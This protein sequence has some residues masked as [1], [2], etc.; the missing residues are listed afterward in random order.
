VSFPVSKAVADVRRIAYGRLRPVRNILGTT[1]DATTTTVSLTLGTSEGVTV[2]V[3]SY[4][5]IDRELMWAYTNTATTTTQTL[6]VARG[7]YGTTAAAH[8]SGARVGV[9]SRF[10]DAF[11]ADAIRD[12]ILGWQPDLFQPVAVDYTVD[13]WPGTV[14]V[15][16]DAVGSFGP[17]AARYL[18]STASSTQYPE[19]EWR[20]MQGMDLASFPS[21]EAIEFLEPT[22]APA[23]WSAQTTSAGSVRVVWA[24]PFD[25]ETF[26]D[27]TDLVESCGLAPSM[28]DVAVLGA[29]IRLLATSEVQRSDMGTAGQPRD[30]AEVSGGAQLQA[31]AQLRGFYLARLDAEQ[32]KL[33]RAYPD[34]F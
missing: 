10:P 27:T 3:P 15:G 24:M 4:L 31:A 14:D 16:G 12:E 9:N 22:S 2:P 23:T 6:T 29:V 34:R 19:V 20:W 26:T 17:A 30:A 13:S 8:T 33:K 21:G 11:I 5:S 28:V 25:V 1:L 32:R 7:E 18:K